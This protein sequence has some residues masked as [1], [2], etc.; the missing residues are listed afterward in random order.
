MSSSAG[1]FARAE[2]HIFRA[3]ALTPQHGVGVAR[4]V[5]VV[6]GVVTSAVQAKGQTVRVVDVDHPAAGGS[7][8]PGVSYAERVKMRGPRLGS[9]AVGN[10]EAHRVEAGA[11]GR[12]LSRRAAV[13]PDSYT[14]E[15]SADAA[16]DAVVVGK[17]PLDSVAE[18]AFVP[19]AAAGQVADRQLEVM[20][21]GELYF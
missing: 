1:S 7:P 5:G 19:L 17:L 9:R 4:L 11:A 12:G 13:L 15:T 16:Y 8:D 3:A 21:A 18:H 6:L 14:G 2:R 20:D 10:R